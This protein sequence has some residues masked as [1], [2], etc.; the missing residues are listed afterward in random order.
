[1]SNLDPLPFVDDRLSGTFS[2][3]RSESQWL[4]TL[5]SADELR[6]IFE[7]PD[8]GEPI[9]GVQPSPAPADPTAT[10]KA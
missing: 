10:A 1:M 8:D 6:Y 2:L 4:L 5:L 7:G 9:V 3:E